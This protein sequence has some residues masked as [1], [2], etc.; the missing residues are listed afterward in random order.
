MLSSSH[1][2]CFILLAALLRAGA[3][4][5]LPNKAVSAQLT[6]D[7][8]NRWD[9]EIAARTKNSRSNTLKGVQE[10]IY[11]GRES[12]MGDLIATFVKVFRRLRWGAKPRV[13]QKLLTKQ[14]SVLAKHYSE[15]VRTYEGLT[16]SGFRIELYF[17]REC[18]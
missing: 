3:D 17:H 11:S 5:N 7:Q 10:I 1:V 15:V 13:F 18:F 9:I 4:V 8:P 6:K 2:H 12:W 16:T 14:Y